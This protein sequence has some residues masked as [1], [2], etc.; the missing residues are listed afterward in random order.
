MSPAAAKPK[1]SSFCKMY[2]IVKDNLFDLPPFFRLIQESSKTP[3]R[4]MYQVFNMGHRMEIYLPDRYAD[5]I[6]RIAAGFGIEAQ[7]V[8]RVEAYTGTKV[9]VDGS[10]GSF[11]YFDA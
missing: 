5:D 9:T 7:V 4:E 3:W 8:G 1:C 11:E 10:F 2:T 6:I